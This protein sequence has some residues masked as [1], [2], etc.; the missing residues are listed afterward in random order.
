MSR[1]LIFDNLTIYSLPV[2]ISF[3][4]LGFDVFY[5][6]QSIANNE[7]GYRILDSL[8]I[9]PLNFEGLYKFEPGLI[10]SDPLGVIDKNLDKL[11][12]KSVL[13]FVSP[14]FEG[15]ENSA[16]KLRLCVRQVFELY[17]YDQSRIAAWVQATQ[18]Q[19]SLI[20]LWVA[21]PSIEMHPW[22]WAKYVNIAPPGNIL[23]LTSKTI[24]YIL[25]KFIPKRLKKK[26]VNT[27]EYNYKNRIL[28]FTHY[29]VAYAKLFEKNYFYAKDPFSV[30]H[31][32]RIIHL[33]VGS[34]QDSFRPVMSFKRL[35][36][37]AYFVGILIRKYPLLY[38]SNQPFRS[39]YLM[40]RVYDQFIGW[41]MGLQPYTDCSLALIGHDILFPKSLSLALEACDIP[42]VAVQE[43]F[44]SP[45][46]SNYSVL[47][48]F[49]LCS[50]SLCVS[51]LEKN[52]RALVG[53]FI[54]IGM[55]RTDLLYKARA[56]AL[57]DKLNTIK[58][59]YKLII[60]LNFHCELNQWQSMS[61][62]ILNWQAH[63]NFI[64]DMLKLSTEIPNV[65]IIFRGKTNEWVDLNEFSDLVAVINRLENVEVDNNYNSFN[66]SY[67]LC[68]QAD[69]IIGKH[70]SLID[71]SLSIGLP[72][73]VH[74]YG[75]NYSE[76][77]TKAFDYSDCEII[78]KDYETLKY[79]AIQKLTSKSE[80]KKHEKIYGIM[81]DGQVCSR[82]RDWITS[83]F[84]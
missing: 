44:I 35:K 24:A 40:A 8:G 74:D 29:G 20:F 71:E 60:A 46:Y 30:M 31:P 11:L 52:G 13:E 64:E 61:N 73:L 67:D 15:I 65:Y 2:A 80:A 55:P 41:S 84:F 76:L 47:M 50:S 4:L 58:R 7:Q 77:I 63:R 54:E 70:T 83:E 66:V 75:H 72:V 69:L 37:F 62:P 81:N 26:L 51:E 18:P 5:L 56:N 57:P 1:I 79:K 49:Y 78:C 16:K 36:S 6:N 48:S 14:F 68:A 9:V 22:G 32:D 33:E 3:N 21:W 23:S 59:N 17:Y 28:Y 43:R 53:K 42:T 45:F 10:D 39:I 27:K 34:S 25:R 12:P 19:N 38:A 82:L